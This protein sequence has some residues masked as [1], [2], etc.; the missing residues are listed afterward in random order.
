MIVMLHFSKR[1]KVEHELESATPDEVEIVFDDGL[2]AG[3]ME[4][5][6]ALYHH[7]QHVE[8][9]IKPLA[10]VRQQVEALAKCVNGT[11]LHYL[12]NQP[13]ASVMVLRDSE[14]V[15]RELVGVVILMNMPCQL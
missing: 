6:G 3:E 13:I 8:K 2:A 4:A 12:C 11:Q 7:L 14:G 9:N 15:V 5:D 1:G 10:S